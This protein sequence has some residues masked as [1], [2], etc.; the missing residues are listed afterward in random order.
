MF[1]FRSTTV[2]VIVLRFHN[3]I[4]K[5]VNLSNRNWL[6]IFYMYNLF[7]ILVQVGESKTIRTNLLKH[8][9]NEYVLTI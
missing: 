9:S 7:P 2:T 6:E 8:T 4:P 5:H 1:P 3:F